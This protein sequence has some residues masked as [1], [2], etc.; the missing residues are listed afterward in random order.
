V[1]EE[2]MH[3]LPHHLPEEVEL[4]EEVVEILLYMQDK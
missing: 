4:V 3:L 1:V 2:E